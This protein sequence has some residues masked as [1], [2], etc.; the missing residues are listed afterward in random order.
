MTPVAAA[1][2]T[3]RKRGP[4]SLAV[5]VLGVAL[6]FSLSR[7]GFTDG[8]ELHRM[9]VFA[10]LR[11]FLVFMG[12]VALTALGLLAAGQWR[13]L[14][15]RAIHRGT[16]VGGLLFGAG[17]TLAGAC[18]GVAFAQLGEGKLWA[19]VSIAGMTVGTLLFSALEHRLR[20]DRGEA[21]G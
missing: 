8:R 16:V 9:F 20:V 10:D 14:P 4:G 6:G 5:L 21:C 3:P 18:P 15:R 2:D 17:W 7:I 1:I 11:M 12:G 19:L 13:T